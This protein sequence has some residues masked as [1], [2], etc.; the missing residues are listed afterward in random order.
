M[1]DFEDLIEETFKEPCE[2][3]SPPTP[4]QL[5]PVF[6]ANQQD[7]SFIPDKDK[8]AGVREKLKDAKCDEH[9]DLILIDF[10]RLGY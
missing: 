7:S 4:A 10:F 2:P 9:E 1:E 6:S 3:E 5:P 8:L